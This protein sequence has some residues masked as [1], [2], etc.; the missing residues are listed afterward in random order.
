VLSGSRFVEIDPTTPEQEEGYDILIQGSD[1]KYP[2]IVIRRKHRGVGATIRT[3]SKFGQHSGDY[4][5]Y[6]SVVEA[7][8]QRRKQRQDNT[9]CDVPAGGILVSKEGWLGTVVQSVVEGRDNS[10]GDRDSA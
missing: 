8:Q 1:R 2:A 10:P 5:D 4:A 7:Y 3:V 6:E 9:P